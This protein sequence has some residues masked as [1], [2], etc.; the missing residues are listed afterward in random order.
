MERKKIKFQKRLYDTETIRAC[1]NEFSEFFNLTVTEDGS[2]IVVE[3]DM[4]TNQEN[5]DLE[6]SNYVLGIIKQNKYSI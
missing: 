4:K 3:L 6:F 1:S 5:I 2:Y